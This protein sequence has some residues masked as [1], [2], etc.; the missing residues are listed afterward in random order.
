MSVPHQIYRYNISFEY[1]SL[2][3]P[4]YSQL[5]DVEA[6]VLEPTLR[7]F[8]LL[9]NLL[10]GFT[11]AGSLISKTPICLPL[12]SILSAKNSNCFPSE[13]GTTANA[14]KLNSGYFVS[15]KSESITG[16]EPNVSKVTVISSCPYSNNLVVSV[17]WTIKIS[18]S[19]IKFLRSFQFPAYSP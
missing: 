4:N 11:G 2:Y 16:T 14:S 10:S 9:F 18:P 6:S 13:P 17:L 8:S 5:P 1:F 7:A 15:L 3:Y 12:R 19:W